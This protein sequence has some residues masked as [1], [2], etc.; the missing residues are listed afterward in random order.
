MIIKFDLNSPKD[1]NIFIEFLRNNFTDGTATLNFDGEEI[2]F[3]YDDFPSKNL[4]SIEVLDLSLRSYNILMRNGIVTVKK[5]KSIYPD[6]LSNMKN[7]GPQS[8]AEIGMALC[9]YEAQ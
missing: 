3:L 1:I 2:S 5:L 9:K 6:G 7:L 4:A 8:I